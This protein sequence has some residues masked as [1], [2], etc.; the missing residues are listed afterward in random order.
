MAFFRFLFRFI[1]LP[2][3]FFLLTFHWIKGAIW[4]VWYWLRRLLS[5]DA[6]VRSWPYGCF[7]T[8]QEDGTYSC[9]PGRKY[10]N[11]FVFRTL[12]SDHARQTPRACDSFC[13]E[14][15]QRHHNRWK[16]GFFRVIG[17]GTFL[18][19]VWSV[20]GYGVYLMSP[21]SSRTNPRKAAEYFTFAE[22]FNDDENYAKALL[23]YNNAV[24]H[25]PDNAVIRLA[26][27]R[28]YLALQRSQD[29]FNEFDVAAG[30]DPTLLE[31]QLELARLTAR[32]GNADRT[33]ELADK[34]IALKPDIPEVHLIK[35]SGLINKR[36]IEEAKV[37]L[38]TA[39]SYPID[40]HE[41]YAVAAF[42]Y[43]ML[44]DY[45]ASEKWYRKVLEIKNDYAEAHIG[46]SYLFN[47]QKRWDLA[48][49]HIDIVLA[50]DSENLKALT[51]LAELYEAQGE[52][53]SAVE[54]YEII[55]GSDEEENV[56][57]KT[58]YAAL[59]IRQGNTDKG[60]KLLRELIDAYPRYTDAHIL[61]SGTY[62]AH[63][64]FSLAVDQVK[65]VLIYDPGNTRAHNVMA[66]AY[67]AQNKYGDAVDSLNKVLEGEP[68]NLEVMLI[69]GRAYQEIDN[70]KMAINVYQTAA[71]KHPASPLPH[72]QLG[73]L[74]RNDGRIDD[75]IAVYEEALQ[76]FPDN[77]TIL[78]NITVF[79]V[80]R[81][82]ADDLDRAEKHARELIA[83]YPGN[84]VVMDTLGLTLLK[85]GDITAAMEW[86]EKSIALKPRYPDSHYHLGKAQMERGNLVEA[87]ASFLKALSLSR[88]FDGADQARAWVESIRE[89]VK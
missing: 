63:R 38:E 22:S 30:L 31:A 27:G 88:S 41:Q 76:Q 73:I 39:I 54:Q 68:E 17:V 9:L 44:K 71:E 12:C 84:A 52:I 10:G 74:H 21:A 86:F 70:D 8:K 58:R 6:K 62:L 29:A 87:E 43:F 18:F 32:R 49:E 82:G 25:D 36:Q 65:K 47:S 42:L 14:N 57:V 61:L 67:L 7:S 20:M 1:R 2:F 23:A 72:M 11:A 15:I 26:R 5:K 55:L 66:R 83:D 69:L 48:R 34:I 78:N 46:L 13:L 3:D 33:L 53:D 4:L 35:A 75:A 89:Q 37:S 28:C 59:L 77:P 56:L 64:M 40:D 79:L 45:E 81:G 50:Q 51:C 85:R 60:S 16:P 24:K 80:D 19:L